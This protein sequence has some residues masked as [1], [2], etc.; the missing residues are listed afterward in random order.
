MS[1]SQN[2]KK[3]I[4]A[5]AARPWRTSQSKPQDFLVWVI[6][7]RSRL[8]S[9]EW[10]QSALVRTESGIQHSIQWLCL[11]PPIFNFLAAGLSLYF[12]PQCLT[13]SNTTFD[14]G[15][16]GNNQRLV[17][18]HVHL[19]NKDAVSRHQIPSLQEY[20]VPDHN[21]TYVDFLARALLPSK[22]SRSLVHY[23]F[24]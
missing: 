14:V 7:V 20:N 18:K 23:L 8:Q 17:Y 16:V 1:I 24:L 3:Q 19:F 21:I 2:E 13:M 15:F 9:L 10:L 4:N 5:N 11:D 12:F 6:A 22:Y